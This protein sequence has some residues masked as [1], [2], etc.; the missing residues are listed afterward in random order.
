MAT[1]EFLGLVAATFTP[2]TKDSDINL[3]VIG[4]YVDYLIHTQGVKKIFVNGTTGEGISLSV[5]ERKLLAEEWIKQGKGKMDEV[6]V[7]V[8]S[9]SLREAQEL[10]RHA[11]TI[12]AD[13]IC[14]ISPSFL[15]PT[16]VGALVAYLNEVASA[17]PEVPFYYYHIPSLTGLNF[18]VEDILD[19]MKKRSSNKG[20]LNPKFRGVKFTGL[21]LLDF[22]QCIHRYGQELSFLYGVD[23]QLL[24]AVVLRANGAVGSTYNFLGKAVGAMLS[25]FQ[26]GDFRS[27]QDKQFLIQEFISYLFHQGLGLADFKRL[28]SLVSNID[29][30]LPRLP[31]QI[32]ETVNLASALDKMKALGLYVAPQA[33]KT[34]STP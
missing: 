21:D 34:S 9:S 16:S 7:H 28:M 8:G 4:R 12:Q 24:S 3:S 15:K 33:S 19:E 20:V 30:G 29:L 10:A 2:M 31:M 27:A 23:E 18:R 11:A 6:I 26:K 14:A 1:Q 5:Q 17:A 13:A 32:N 22:G 25:D